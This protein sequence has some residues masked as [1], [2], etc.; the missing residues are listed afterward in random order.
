MNCV[1]LI[2]TTPTRPFYNTERKV[3]SLIY[4]LEIPQ[5]IYQNDS[6]GSIAC[7]F[8]RA[9]TKE[10]RSKK[11]QPENFEIGRFYKKMMLNEINGVNKFKYCC[12]VSNINTLNKHLQSTDQSIDSAY[13]YVTRNLGDVFLSL[14][15]LTL[16]NELSICYA[17]CPDLYSE[18]IVDTW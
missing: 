16:K 10:I 13:Y 2:T 7:R 3:G 12:Q 6:V 17:Y 11:R 14:Y 1:R 9:L 5:N 15:V 4:P 18:E 8:Q